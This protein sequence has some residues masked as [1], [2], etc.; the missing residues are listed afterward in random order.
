[1]LSLHCKRKQS[2]WNTIGTKFANSGITTFPELGLFTS[3]VQ[4]ENQAFLGC[5]LTELNTRSIKGISTKGFEGLKVAEP[6]VFDLLATVQQWA[7]Y[8]SNVQFSAFIIRTTQVP[9]F[10]GSQL[11]YYNFKITNGIYVRDELVEDFKV[12]AGWSERASSIKPLSECPYS[13][14]G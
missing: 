12:A 3:V 7:F 9:N 6:L 2:R 11:F 8:S 5:N 14:P 13:I 10:T 1:M 4:V